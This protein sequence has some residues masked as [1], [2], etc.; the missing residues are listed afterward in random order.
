MKSKNVF[1]RKQSCARLLS[2][3]M[4]GFTL[5]EIA[6]VL[7]ISGLVFGGIWA[8]ANSTWQGYRS[9]SAIRQIGVVLGN[10]RDRY[11]AISAWPA[12]M[13]G[14]ITSI[15]DKENILPSDMRRN[16]SKSGGILDHAMSRGA[17]GG[18]FFIHTA[19]TPGGTPAV[20]LRFLYLAKP[21]CIN[22]LTLLPIDD[23]GVGMVKLTV[24]DAVS[25][26]I[27]QDNDWNIRVPILPSQAEKWCNRGDDNEV[28]LDFRLH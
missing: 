16:P 7:A 10:V 18:S 27:K 21:N 15:V 4:R 25:E 20:Q 9:S 24:N 19:K 1:N 3:G 13:S 12:G 22:F 23:L 6:I 17:S 8:A 2:R 11:A 28:Y 14:D 5:T 26:S